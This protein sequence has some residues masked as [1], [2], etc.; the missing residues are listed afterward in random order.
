[1]CT[2]SSANAPHVFVSVLLHLPRLNLSRR[3]SC[4]NPCTTPIGPTRR[5]RLMV[6]KQGSQV[7]GGEYGL[8]PGAVFL[9][10]PA[11][12]VPQAKCLRLPDAVLDAG[13][14][15]VPQFQPSELPRKAGTSPRGPSA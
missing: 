13:V 4:T 7:G 14:L 12:Q 11:G 3:V 10:A 15:A 9:L 8:E 6:R 5:F 1:M 2:A